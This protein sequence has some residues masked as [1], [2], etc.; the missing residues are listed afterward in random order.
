[1]VIEI[2][3]RKVVVQIKNKIFSFKNSE[4]FPAALCIGPKGKD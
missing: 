1:M 4:N 3:H 2:L